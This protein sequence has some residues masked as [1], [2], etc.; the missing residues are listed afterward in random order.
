[1]KLRELILHLEEK[2]PLPRRA[3]VLTIDDGYRD[4]YEIAVQLLEKYEIPATLFP[5]SEYVNRSPEPL[6][7]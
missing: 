1:M 2:I 3:V 4:F 5:V 6:F 7:Q